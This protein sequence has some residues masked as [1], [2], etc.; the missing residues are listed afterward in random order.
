MVTGLDIKP[1]TARARRARNF[2]I[3]CVLTKFLRAGQNPK[4]LSLSQFGID[5]QVGDIRGN[6]NTS[7]K[8]CFDNIFDRLG[9]N[10]Q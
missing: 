2:K 9:M 8:C 7:P 1:L 5:D 10:T 6:V 4:L 3:L